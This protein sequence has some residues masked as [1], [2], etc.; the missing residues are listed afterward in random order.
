MTYESTTIKSD[1]VSD[2]LFDLNDVI[3]ILKHHSITT[4]MLSDYNS[5]SISE[6]TKTLFDLPKDFEKILALKRT[7]QN[8]FNDFTIFE[9]FFFS[10]AEKCHCASATHSLIKKKNRYLQILMV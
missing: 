6:S 9:S 1:D 5:D 4:E 2:M 10:N 3:N 7:R 8:F